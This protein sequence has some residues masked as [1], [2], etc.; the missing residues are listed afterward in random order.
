MTCPRLS[1]WRK[2]GRTCVGGCWWE[3][4]EQAKVGDVMHALSKSVGQRV[5]GFVICELGRSVVRGVT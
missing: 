3:E 5:K 2:L 4:E 1:F